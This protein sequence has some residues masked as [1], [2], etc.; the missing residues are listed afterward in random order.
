M[1]LH[2]RKTI[3]FTAERLEQMQ[4]EFEQ[5]QQKEKEVLKRLTTAREMGDLSENGAYKYAKFELGSVRRQMNQLR[6]FLDKGFAISQSSHSDSVTFGS[7]V[8]IQNKQQEQTFTIVNKHE[9][10]MAQKKL[11]NTS[12][13]GK[14]LMHKKVGESVKV[15]TPGGS[16][17]VTILKIA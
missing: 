5:L 4:I 9:S 6:K 10:D 12:P 13:I 7:V 8:T 1:Q 17:T 15:E 14:A 2:H 16:Q 3:P 11:S